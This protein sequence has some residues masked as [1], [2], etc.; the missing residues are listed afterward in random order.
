[1]TPDIA[2]QKKL[3][4][5]EGAIVEEVT[6]GTG[7]EKAGVKVG[8]VV[9]AVDGTPVRSM[10]DLILQVRRHSAGDTVELTL[11]RDGKSIKLSVVVGDKPASLATTPTPSPAPKK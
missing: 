3:T 4:I 5:E 11:L 2:A 7:A 8:D 10:S 1:V 6:K 9:T